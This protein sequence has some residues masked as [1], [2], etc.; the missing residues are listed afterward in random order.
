[1]L[2]ILLHLSAFDYFKFLNELINAYYFYTFGTVN[3]IESNVTKNIFKNHHHVY[4]F[5]KIRY[6]ISFTS[7]TNHNPSKYLED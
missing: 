6:K 2:H 1:M 7:K 3:K 4:I 5:S